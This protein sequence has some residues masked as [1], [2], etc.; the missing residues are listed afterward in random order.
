MLYVDVQVW[1]QYSQSPAGGSHPGS[2]VGGVWELGK[3]FSGPL[4]EQYK[5]LTTELSL[6]LWQKLLAKASLMVFKSV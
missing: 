2:G 6:L 1:M 4:Q 3:Q 5:L